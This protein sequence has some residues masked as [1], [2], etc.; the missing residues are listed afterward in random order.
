MRPIRVIIVAMETKNAFH[1]YFLCSQAVV[2]NSINIEN[3]A[4]RTSLPT[5]RNIFM[6]SKP[7]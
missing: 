5:I 1:F 3:V 6:A 7:T 2:N 4:I